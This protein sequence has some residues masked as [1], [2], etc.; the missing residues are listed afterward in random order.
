MKH[1]AFTLDAKVRDEEGYVYQAKQIF[2]PTLPNVRHKKKYSESKVI[3]ILPGFLR[4]L[5]YR[6]VNHKNNTLPFSQ[7]FQKHPGCNDNEAGYPGNR[8]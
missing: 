2:A 6:Y 8:I 7:L 1:I 4:L 5:T 3:K